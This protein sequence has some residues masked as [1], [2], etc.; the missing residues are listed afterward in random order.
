MELSTFLEIWT[1]VH[2][3]YHFKWTGAIILNEL[4]S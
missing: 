1:S 2:R 3:Y 4:E